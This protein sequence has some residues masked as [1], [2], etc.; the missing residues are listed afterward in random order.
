MSAKLTTNVDQRLL[1][2]TKFPAEFNT[3]VDMKKINIHIIKKW[4]S[5]ELAR[6]LKGEDDVVTELVFNI[7][8]ENRFV[9]GRMYTELQSTVLTSD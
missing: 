9:S 2:T 1:R 5:D 6:L 7:I 3:K 4:V 8:E